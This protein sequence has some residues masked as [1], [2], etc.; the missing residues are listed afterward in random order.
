MN[1]ANWES[2]LENKLSLLSS[3]DLL[4][5]HLKKAP[6][7]SPTRVYLAGFIAGRAKAENNSIN[8]SGLVSQRDQAYFDYNEGI[9]DAQS[10]G[11]SLQNV[12]AD[13][14]TASI[15]NQSIMGEQI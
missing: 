10:V 7:K 1:T 12:I 5:D 3:L 8:L 11:K 4:V 2:H 13:I 15:Y 14:Q 6:S 9:E